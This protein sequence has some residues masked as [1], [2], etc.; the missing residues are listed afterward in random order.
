LLSLA[1]SASFGFRLGFRFEDL[2][3]VE[4]VGFR[5]WGLGSGG[6]R[7]QGLGLLRFE[8]SLIVESGSI[9]KP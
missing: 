9:V 7:L 2:L 8:D 3:M 4:G 5:V 1:S 6:F